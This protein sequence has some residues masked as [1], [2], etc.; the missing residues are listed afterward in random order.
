MK[1]IFY[2]FLKILFAILDNLL[3]IAIIIFLL[4]ENLSMAIIVA[5]VAIPIEI[6][7]GFHKLEKVNEKENVKKIIDAINKTAK[8]TLKKYTYE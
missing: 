8:E 1:K 6:N 4:R 5:I 3:F 7:K 2:Y